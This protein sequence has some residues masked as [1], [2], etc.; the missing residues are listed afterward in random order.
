MSIFSRGRAVFTWLPTEQVRAVRR[1]M[2]ACGIVISTSTSTEAQFYRPGGFEG[3]TPVF[4]PRP[5][6][7]A[8]APTAAKP[9][10]KKHFKAR[11]KIKQVKKVK[12]VRRTVGLIRREKPIGKDNSSGRKPRLATVSPPKKLRPPRRSRLTRKPFRKRPRPQLPPQSVD[13]RAPVMFGAPAR[14]MTQLLL[15]SLKQQQLVVY[16][17][18]R[19]VAVTRVSTGKPGHATPI[20]IFSILEKRRHHRSNI[21]ANAPMP[22][23]QRLTWSGI[24]LHEGDVP[25]YPA[26]H[27]CIRL[28]G[29]FASGLFRFTRPGVHVVVSRHA[30]TP[31]PIRH[32]LLPTWADPGRSASAPGTERTSLPQDGSVKR[33]DLVANARAGTASRPGAALPKPAALGMPQWTTDGS[34]GVRLLHPA[35]LDEE[36]EGQPLR[37]LIRPLTREERLSGAKRLLQ[38][39][40]YDAGRHDGKLTRKARGAIS[41]FRRANGMRARGGPTPKFYAALYTAAGVA[42]PPA[43]RLKVRQGSKALY[44]AD[45]ALEEPHRPLGTHLFLLVRKRHGL[46][47]ARV[48]WQG[49][50]GIIGANGI[51]CR[52]R[53]QRLGRV[54]RP[55]RVGPV[56]HCT[57]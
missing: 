11:V 48:A 30:A 2:L 29:P 56:A 53:E 26:S 22:F 40:G 47:G 8:P 13:N 14:A 52:G 33:G 5:R 44:A 38:R 1:V 55:R 57:H 10:L 28:P 49:V 43:L 18:G 37:V 45:V 17:N 12:R 32:V 9:V 19:R 36:D 34:K 23:M 7:P 15:I 3:N 25:D 50:A 54:S 41:A 16:E 21:Y 35:R 4:R 27:G 46:V 24:A 20:G 6:P 42:H 51:R 39:L 31:F